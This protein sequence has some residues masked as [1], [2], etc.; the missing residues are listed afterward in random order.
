MPNSIPKTKSEINALLKEGYVEVKFTKVDG[1]T[2]TMLATLLPDVITHVA[3]KH[4]ASTGSVRQTPEHQVSCIDAEKGEWRSFRIDSI[5]SF[6]P[7]II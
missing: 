1:S 5:T 4:G 6:E 3:A 7:K 2:R